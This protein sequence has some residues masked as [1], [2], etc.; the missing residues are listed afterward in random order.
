MV[1]R[2]RG[3]GRQRHRFARAEGIISL[4][5][6]RR[7]RSPATRISGSRFRWAAGCFS[8]AIPIRV[9]QAFRADVSYMPGKTGWGR[10]LIRL[11]LRHSGRG[12]LSG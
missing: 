11:R 8:A 12:G 5:S 9:A 6:R 2:R 3:V 7:I 4:A 1:S 10:S